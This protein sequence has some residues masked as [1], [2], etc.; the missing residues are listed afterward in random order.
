MNAKAQYQD[1]MTPD[2]QL[3]DLESRANSLGTASLITGGT[4]LVFT[5]FGIGFHV[6]FGP[7]HRPQLTNPHQ[8]EAASP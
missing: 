7:G 6:K 1:P 4:A 8:E 5:G 3:G 2:E